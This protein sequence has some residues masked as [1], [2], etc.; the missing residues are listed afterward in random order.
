MSSYLVYLKIGG[1]AL[2][3]AIAAGAGYHFG[4]LASKTAL[5]ADH[6][7][8]AK[9]ATD[10]LLAQRSQAAAQ[11]ITDNTAEAAHDKTIES[12]PARV[13]RTPVFLRA[14]GDVCPDVVPA[15]QAQTGGAD[16]A[17][18]AAEQG[19]GEHDL[20]PALEAFKLKYETV[21]ADCRR[22]DVE[23]PK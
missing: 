15:T 2:L 20:R 12:L 6:A 17:G 23:W 8:M 22:L 18:R 7:A 9:V 4:G 14:P 1:A 19:S 11:A 10:A 13:I 21:L 3:L 16:P 5:E